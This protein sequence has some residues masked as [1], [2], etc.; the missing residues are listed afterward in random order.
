MRERA[1]AAWVEPIARTLAEDNRELLG[2]VR[3]QPREFWDRQS[4]AEGWTNRDILAHVGGG[5]DQLV[6]IVLRAVISHK[7]LGPETFDIDTDAA[8]AHGVEERRSWPLERVIAEIE[9]G[10]EETQY[11]LSQLSDTDR[12][13]RGGSPMTLGDFLRI[14]QKERHDHLHLQ[15]LRAS[16]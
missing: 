11:L 14:V 15:Q 16:R 8:N 13:V 7:P 6:Q 10:E 9:E 5:N 1:Y 12:D 2:F 3:A 4:V